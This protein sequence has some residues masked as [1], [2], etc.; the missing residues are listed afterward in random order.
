VII[1]SHRSDFPTAIERAKLRHEHALLQELAGPGI[2][3]VLPLSPAGGRIA[4]V[5]EGG[6]LCSLGRMVAATPDLCLVLRTAI[7]V[8][9]LLTGGHERVLVHK[10]IQPPNL[11]AGPDPL[12]VYLIDWGIASR[13][14]EVH[15]TNDAAAPK[16][17]GTLAYIA[18]EQ[19]G[20][21]NRA[22]DAR[23]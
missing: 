15:G 20:L 6:W 1:K 4:L 2:A 5:M 16:A 11:L 10:D 12:R 21:M 3:P 14:R 8:T 18:P 22:I 23:A 13:L 19:T 17:E 7:G 9:A